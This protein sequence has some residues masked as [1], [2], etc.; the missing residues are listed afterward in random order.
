MKEINGSN[1]M[2][3]I[4]ITEDQRQLIKEQYDKYN[5]GERIKSQGLTD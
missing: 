3:T 1:I 2:K 4:K 5:K